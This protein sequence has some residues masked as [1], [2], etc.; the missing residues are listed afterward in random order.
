MIRRRILPPRNA[1]NF[2]A[3]ISMC[4]LIAKRV[5]GLSSLK[6]SCAK[7][8]IAPQQGPVL[9]QRRHQRSSDHAPAW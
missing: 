5:R 2:A 3:M 8:E 7:H 6:Q 1:V 4:Q 9:V